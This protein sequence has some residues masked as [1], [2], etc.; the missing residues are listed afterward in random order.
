MRHAVKRRRMGD[1]CTTPHILNLSTRW[2]WL[3]SSMPRPPY[4]DTERLYCPLNR[5]PTVDT[6]PD[7]SRPPTDNYADRTMSAP[8]QDTDTSIWQCELIDRP[9]YPSRAQNHFSA[10]VCLYRIKSTSC[11][12]NNKQPF[13]TVRCA[14]YMF[15]PLCGH[16]QG[17]I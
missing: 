5:R 14:S 8:K 12:I 11:T 4:P 9:S 7:P 15:R 6:K 1:G 3:I 10:T 13:A 2:K 16:L 17:I